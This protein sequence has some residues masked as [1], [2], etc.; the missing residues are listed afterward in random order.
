MPLPAAAAWWLGPAAMAT[1]K[2]MA[3]EYLPAV[4][5]ATLAALLTRLAWNRYELQCAT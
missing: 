1:A 5:S 3:Y 2:A 4:S